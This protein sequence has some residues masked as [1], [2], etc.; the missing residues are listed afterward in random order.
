MGIVRAAHRFRASR[1]G[2]VVGWITVLAMASVA[3]RAFVTLILRLLSAESLGLTDAVL[4]SLGLFAARGSW[5]VYVALLQPTAQ[6][7]KHNA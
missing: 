1:T 7:A 3:M 2:K 5:A 6:A 4:F